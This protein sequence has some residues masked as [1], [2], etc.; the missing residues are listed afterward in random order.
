[1]SIQL[2]IIGT[3]WLSETFLAAMDRVEGIELAAV[4]SRSL[5]KAAKFAKD[6]KGV[7][8]YNDPAALA[9]DKEIDAVYIATP[10]FTHYALSKQMLQANKH[11]I[12]EK[13]VTV[14]VE[15]YDEL[16]ALAEKKG[17]IYMEAMMS[18]HLPQLAKLKN[19]LSMAG[20]PVMARFDFCQRSSKIDGVRRGEVYSTFS[21]AACG[22]A[23]MDLG[24]YAVYL[25]LM[26]FGYPGDVQAYSI[27]ICDVDGSDTIVLQ[28]DAFHVVVTLSKLAESRIRSEIILE[29]GTVTIGLLSQLQELDYYPVAGEKVALYGKNDFADSMTGEIRDFLDYIAGKDMS[30]IKALARESVKLLSQIRQKI[31]Y[32]I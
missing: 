1:M 27:P 14:H 5:E 28:Y 17:L 25:A 2:A 4:C 6:R 7:K 20:K 19:T 21:K 26:L 8:L 30:E 24:V 3:F 9:E 23:L 31:G 11:V 16:C 13:P 10:N 12:C 15:E 32:D 18:A 22:G 29:K